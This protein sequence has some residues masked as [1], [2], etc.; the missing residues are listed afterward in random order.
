[1]TTSTQ[2]TPK[3]QLFELIYQAGGDCW[4]RFCRSPG[5]VLA[6]LLLPDN[7]VRVQAK[8]LFLLGFGDRLIDE[9][10]S[11]RGPTPAPEQFE[12]SWQK[13]LAQA[14]GEVL[15]DGPAYPDTPDEVLAV[16]RLIYLRG[17][18]DA[19]FLAADARAL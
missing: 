3:E 7:N 18:D 4:R 16:A 12:R 19:D 2:P 6:L 13:Y 14:N 15:L 11:E 10:Y 8:K 9:Y 1:M 17:Y 5:G